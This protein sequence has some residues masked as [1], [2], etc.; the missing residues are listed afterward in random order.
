MPCMNACWML[1]QRHYHLTRWAD[2]P[3]SDPYLWQ[4]LIFHLCRTDRQDALRATL[5][6]LGYLTR[7][8]LYVSV[9]AL[10][11]DLVLASTSAPDIAPSLLTPLRCAIVRISHLLRQVHTPTEMGGLLLGHLGWEPAC[12]NQQFPLEREL[13]RP[14]LTAWHPLPDQASSALLRTLHGHSDSVEGCV[15][16]PDGRFIVSA[17]HD[18]T[19]KVWDTTTG[20]ERLSLTGHTNWVKGC[21]VSPDGCFIVSASQDKTLKVWD[22][23]TGVERFSLTGH[24]S[25]VYSCAVSP[26][27]RFIVSASYDRTLKVWDAATGVERLSLTGH[28]DSVEG[29]AVSPDGRFIVS[30]SRDKTLKVWD[31]ATGV[32]R[33]SLTGHSDSV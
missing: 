17:S 2:L 18:K 24:T 22:T 16:S 4:H 27:G 29:C 23:T 26:D 7:K 31:A 25:A 6:D 32:E 13:P 21:A 20:V 9:P 11:A 33:L 10:E 14:F 15:V 28:S 3:P 1:T 5:T 8:A 19:L 12:A 30:A